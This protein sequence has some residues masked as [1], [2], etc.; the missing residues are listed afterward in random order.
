MNET[1]FFCASLKQKETSP[2]NFYPRQG[3]KV[4]LKE[5]S[6]FIRGNVCRSPWRMQ[7]KNEI[8][9]YMPKLAHSLIVTTLRKTA[10]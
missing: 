10:S 1:S 2:A 7:T 3:R 5:I 8:G 6:L 4:Y 9:E